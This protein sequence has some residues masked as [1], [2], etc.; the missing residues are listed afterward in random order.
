MSSI[1]SLI[2]VLL[3]VGGVIFGVYKFFFGSSNSE[4]NYETSYTNTTTYG[5]RKNKIIVSNNIINRFFNSLCTPAKFYTLFIGLSLILA[6]FNGMSILVILINLIF[7]IIWV[8]ILNYIC[9]KGFS[10]F[11]WVLVLLPFVFLFSD[12][13]RIIK[14]IQN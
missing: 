3:L 8:K 7:S 1:V 6:L 5:G 9:S 2:L 13:S 10:W 12:V 11:S 4:Y 14:T